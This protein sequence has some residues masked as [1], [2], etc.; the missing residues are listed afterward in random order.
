MSR[1]QRLRNIGYLNNTQ[2]NSPSSC[3]TSKISSCETKDDCNNCNRSDC[4]CVNRYDYV[5]FIKNTDLSEPFYDVQCNGSW[6]RR[7]YQPLYL[8]DII[9]STPN[10]LF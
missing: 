4:G 1:Y 2:Y 6:N 10:L 5:D 9:I 7:N 8:E 3:E